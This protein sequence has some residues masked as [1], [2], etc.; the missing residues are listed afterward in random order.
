[1]VTGQP[2]GRS[3]AQGWVYFP[4]GLRP[5][6]G[7]AEGILD[8]QLGQGAGAGV[9]TALILCW[10]QREL[11]ASAGTRRGPP[12]PT[13][14]PLDQQEQEGRAEGW[15]ESPDHCWAESHCLRRASR[16]AV[17]L[18]GPVRLAVQVK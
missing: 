11:G 16:P 8:L 1:M 9:G 6:A 18:S 4:Y 10:L 13:H 5:P 3:P 2:G 14:L 7:A 17:P 15:K 12:P